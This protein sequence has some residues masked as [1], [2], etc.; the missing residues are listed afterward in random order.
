MNPT[1][2][3]ISQFQNY[4]FPT[5]K[6]SA[7]N[8]NPGI[9]SP[10]IKKNLGRYII[11]VQFQRLRTDIQMWRDAMTEAELA[12]Y[13]QR[14]KMQRITQDTILN[15][16]VFACI[17]LRKRLTRMRDFKICNSNGIEND[18]LKKL[19]RNS[20][21]GVSNNNSTNSWFDDFINYTL[22]ALEFGYSLISLGDIVNNSYPELSLIKRWNVAPDRFNVTGF[23]YS[24]S[25]KDFFDSEYADWHVYVSTPSEVG[26]SACGFGYL[27]KVAF[28]EI[29]LRN[30]LGYNADFNEMFNQ[31]ARIGKTDKEGYQRDRFE[32]YLK[33]WGASNYALL[34]KDSDSLELIE[35]KSIGASYQSFGS[36]DERMQK[37]ISKIILGHSDAMDSTPGKLGSSQKTD[38]DSS[39]VN[40]ALSSIQMED[41]LFCQNVINGKL[42]PRMRKHGFKI[43]IDYHFE[44]LNDDEKN[45]IRKN[46]DKS[47]A[48]TATIALTMANAGLQMDNKYFTQRTNIPCK[49][50]NNLPNP[51]NSPV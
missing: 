44:W 4:L 22:E 3:N 50:I 12:Y 45:E 40:K 49:P 9:G 6:A 33:N 14:V 41:G 35:S 16:H 51:I 8:L 21:M 43:P 13:P 37:I 28:Y 18:D 31:P 38:N 20:A 39:P 17:E 32:N 26:S 23:V 25:G 24:L 7:S 42:L 30:N 15:G 1:S 47:N 48:I 19:F 36:F 34:D 29:L 5:D 10:D 11:P 2:K 27:Y 46:E